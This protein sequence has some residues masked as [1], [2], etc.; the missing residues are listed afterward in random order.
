MLQTRNPDG[1]RLLGRPIYRWKAKTKINFKGKIRGCGVDLSNSGQGKVE[2]HNEHSIS[3]TCGEFFLY[4]REFKPLKK[5]Y[6]MDIVTP[7]H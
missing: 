5:H 6:S 1:N 4:L 7:Y 3:V 2:H